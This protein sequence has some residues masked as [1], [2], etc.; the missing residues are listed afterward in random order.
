M[1][2]VVIRPATSADLPAVQSLLRDALLP[3]D[4]VPDFFP[5]NYAVGESGGEIVAAIGV[6]RYGDHGLLR[7]A[8]VADAQRGTGLGSR[9]TAERVEWCR[10]QHMRSMYLLTTTAAPFFE[11]MGFAR[12]DRSEVPAEVQ[13]APEFATVCPTSAVV[14]RLACV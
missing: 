13:A 8:V 4:G 6:E 5:D 11:R 14:M 10:S 9:L 2:D 7:S 3:L 1:S 12:V